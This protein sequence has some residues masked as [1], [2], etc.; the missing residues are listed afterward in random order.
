M[1]GVG[2]DLDKAHVAIERADPRLPACVT[3][4]EELDR[5]LIALYPA[6]SNHLMDLDAL[7]A[8]DVEFF[9]AR[10]DADVVG[11]GAIKRFDDYAEIKRVFVAPRARGLGVAR[12]IIQVLENAA[13]AAGLGTLRLETGILQPEA[14]ALFESAGFVRRGSFGGYP[15]DDP[16]SVFMERRLP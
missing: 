14:L 11:C 2:K 8:P 15:A 10:V 9:A 16:Y 12:R 5:H 4:I 1:N 3:L 13:R 7:A 6:E